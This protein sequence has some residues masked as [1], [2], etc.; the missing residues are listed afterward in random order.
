[1]RLVLAATALSLIFAGGA[2]AQTV[3]AGEHPVDPY[4]QSNANAAATPM[5]DDSVLKAF[6]GKE[7]LTRITSDLVDRNIADPRIKD[8][9]ATAD[10]V[11]L[12]RTLAE[13]FC[14]ILAGPASAGGCDYTGKD[15]GATHKD[16]GITPRDFNALVENLQRA[17]DKEGVP[18]AAQN[19]LLAKL[20]PMSKQ[21]IERK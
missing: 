5:R 13:Q 11:R 19:K 4:L 14:Y 1:M 18:F 16:Q 7:G 20:A 10:V 8:I 2:S 6:H 3:P 15:M 12:K 9:F 21:V 17:M